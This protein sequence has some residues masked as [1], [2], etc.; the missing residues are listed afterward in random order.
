MQ[1]CNHATLLFLGVL[2]FTACRTPN[3]MPLQTAQVL[4]AKISKKTKANY[5]LFLPEG[6]ERKSSGPW[7][8]ILFLHGIG[9]RGNDPWKV[10]VHGPPKIAEWFLEHER[11]PAK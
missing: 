7:P 9:E 5:L 2:A 3:S 8:L 10:K 4:D 6:Y 1:L 11:K